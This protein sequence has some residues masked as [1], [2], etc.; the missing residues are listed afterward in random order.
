MCD[1]RA[2]R[3]A[4]PG[5]GLQAR[6]RRRRRAQ[7]RRHGRLLA[8][9]GRRRRRGRAADRSGC[10]EPTLHELR[11]R[12]IDYRGVLYAGLMLTA[13]GPEGARVQRALRRPRGPGRAAPAGRATSRRC[14]PAAARRVVARRNR[15]FV[16]ATP[17]SRWCA[18]PRATPRRRGPATVIDGLG[19]R[20]R[21]R[22]GVARVLRRRGRGRRRRR[23][24]PPAAGCSTSPALGP[25]VAE[26]RARAYAAVAHSAGPACSSAPTSPRG[27][28][29]RP[30]ASTGAR[31][32]DSFGVSAARAGGRPG[33]L[34]PPSRSSRRMAMPPMT[35]RPRGPHDVTRAC[36]AP[37]GAPARSVTNVTARLPCIAGSLSLIAP[38]AA[39]PLA[40][41]E[42]PVRPRADDHEVCCAERLQIDRGDVADGACPRPGGSA[43]AR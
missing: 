13:D 3:A 30:R 32:G 19:R 37:C 1:G 39:R 38:A 26:A 24:S 8:G 15:P 17:P 6:R 42:H 18:R 40:E 20:R 33:S 28:D 12:G 11:R 41:E 22:P 31:P 5:P 4:G 27:S 34:V 25:T 23:S 7:H 14:W 2:G 29:P 43:P 10:V 16:D 36:R 21:P 35:S 9:A